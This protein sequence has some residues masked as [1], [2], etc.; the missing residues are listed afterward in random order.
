MTAEMPDISFPLISLLRGIRG[1]VGAGLHLFFV[2]FFLEG[3]TFGLQQWVSFPFSMSV[4]IKIVMTL[5]CISVCLFGVIW[6]NC[7][8]NL[9]KT[10]LLNGKKEL[11]THGPFSFVRHP[12]YATLMITMP[13]LS[14]IWCSDLIF[15]VPWV[16]ILIISHYVVRFE[17]RGLI[18]L[19]G[20]EYKKY[21]RHV[22]ALL[23]FK[24][25]GGQQYHRMRL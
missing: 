25:A 7:T 9:I 19:F 14:I 12:L 21:Q 8:L 18:K 24:G 4:P 16:L 10:H 17:E 15:T 23:P 3:V 22:P 20:D 13:P 2:G 6:F 5:P 11:I 1:L